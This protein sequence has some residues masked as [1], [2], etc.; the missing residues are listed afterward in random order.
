[1]TNLNSQ[2]D[3]SQGSVC[4]AV[5]RYLHIPCPQGKASTCMLVFWP[6]CFVV[7]WVCFC[8]SVFI[9]LK[10]LPLSVDVDESWEN[11][12][13]QPFPVCYNVSLHNY[14]LPTFLPF[15]DMQALHTIHSAWCSFL[16]PSPFSSLLLNL[17]DRLQRLVR[18]HFLG[19]FQHSLSLQFTPL[20]DI[21][22]ISQ[23]VLAT[24]HCYD[25]F[26]GVFNPLHWDLFVGT[27]TKSEGFPYFVSLEP[28]SA[29]VHGCEWMNQGGWVGEVM[30]E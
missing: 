22:P 24:L 12:P 21:A 9:N 26:I 28:V 27:H 23:R 10:L 15:L 30:V 7:I 5:G 1:M 14:I 6:F 20:L 19:S 29:S 16:W 18:C 3:H 4:P 8:S 17:G 13:P 2:H 11:H 25:L